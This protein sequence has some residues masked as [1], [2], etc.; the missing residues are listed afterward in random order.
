MKKYISILFLIIITLIIIFSIDLEFGKPINLKFANHY[1]NQGLDETGA[2]NLVASVYL[3]YRAYDTLIET[4][5][6]FM[7]VYGISFFLRR[8]K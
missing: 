3:D 6:L 2:M 1:I 8:D 4:V 7:A 5:I